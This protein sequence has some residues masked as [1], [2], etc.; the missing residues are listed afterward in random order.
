MKYILKTTITLILFIRVAFGQQQVY[1]GL[2]IND[3]R[4]WSGTIIIEGDVTITE[5]GRLTIE[6]GTKILFK[7]QMDKANSGKD[8]TRSE[9]IVKGSL[10]VKGQMERKVTF[11]SDSKGPRM[12]DWYGIYL[13]NPRQISII[14]YAV[15][16]YGYNGIMIKNSHPVIRNSQI[17]LNYNAGILCEVKAEPK[18]TKN[19][20]SENGYGGVI[21]GLGAKPVLS[22]NLISLNEIGV[23]ALSLSQ[24]N[25]GNLK[26]GNNYNIGQNNIF[27]NTEYDLY[28]HTKLPLYAENNSWGNDNNSSISKRIY[29]SGDDSQYGVVDVQPIYRQT[30]LDDLIQIA[31]ED[32]PTNNQENEVKEQQKVEKPPKSNQNTQKPQTKKPLL[33]SNTS[34]NSPSGKLADNNNPN[35]VTDTKSEEKTENSKETP[36]ATEVIKPPVNISE[37]EER[38][39][40]ALE[41]EPAKPQINYDQI[42]LEH[43]LDNR[44]KILKKVA[45]RVEQFGPKG[46]VI[47]RAIIDKN[48]KVESAKIVKGLSEYN[49]EI[50]LEA[51]EKFVFSPG[52]VKGIPVKFYTNLFFE[53]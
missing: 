19:I 45:P 23:V 36:L 41:Q 34:T 13:M 6:P 26:K 42:F 22:H 30:N 49:D 1:S 50:S 25:L 7:P 43:F 4:T 20:I 21:S 32:N 14:D 33:A 47:I 27:E 48:G 29:D 39:L 15:I 11:S 9:L 10:I 38:P 46:R 16:E 35:S 24:P 44:K 40:A 3:T 28:N 2:K 5:K 18:I 12:G 51:A 37:E 8:K 53:F 17:H 52:T 31:Q